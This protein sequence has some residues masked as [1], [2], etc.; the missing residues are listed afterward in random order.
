MAVDLVND[1]Q[2][3][4][5]PFAFAPMQFVHADGPDAFELAMGQAPLH[6]PLHRT[7]HALPTGVEGPGR[8][9]PRQSPCP[10]GKKAHQGDGDGPFALAPG[11]MLD[12]H[13]VSGALHP[14]R[15]MKEKGLD[16]P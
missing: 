15:R 10:A 1:D 3:I 12:H 16:T 13:S 11:N 8:L 4:V 2:K 7:I 5:R 9:P 6:K 14:P